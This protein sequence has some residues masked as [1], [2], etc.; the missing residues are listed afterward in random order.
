MPG[1]APTPTA[2]LAARGSWRADE[3]IN[4][5]QDAVAAPECP[6]W[7]KGEARKEWFRVVPILLARRTLSEADFG[8]LSG[9]CQWWGEYVNAVRRV[10]QLRGTFA[11]HPIDH[12]RVLKSQ[13]WKE[14]A[15]A[16]QQF[17]LSPASRT[18]VSAASG[19]PT[20]DKSRFFGG[21][22][23]AAG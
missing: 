21:Q 18:R 11:G 23:A 2:I 3:R 19:K 8:H 9:M 22:S 17:G 5:P 13:A 14:Y 4:E 20:N 10:R 6:R 7:L 12:P 16:A 15:K 1:P